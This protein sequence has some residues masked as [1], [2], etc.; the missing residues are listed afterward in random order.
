MR[1]R[2]GVHTYL[3]LTGFLGSRKQRE[4]R[5]RGRKEREKGHQWGDT[6][7]GRAGTAPLPPR[8]GGSGVAG[9]SLPP[10]HCPARRGESQ[11]WKIPDFGSEGLGRSLSCLLLGRGKKGIPGMPRDAQESGRGCKIPTWEG[12]RGSTKGCSSS[13]AGAF[14]LPEL[15]WLLGALNA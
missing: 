11:G 15:L 13:R 1:W 12:S 9:G 10:G 8:L 5:G 6:A 7:T 2:R 4:I 3:Y 14:L